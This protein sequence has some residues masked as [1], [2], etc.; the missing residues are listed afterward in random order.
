MAPNA[1]PGR[2]GARPGT[3]PPSPRRPRTTVTEVRVFGRPGPDD[4]DHGARDDRCP[5]SAPGRAWPST[6]A[7][8]SSG[9][10]RPGGALLDPCEVA[11]YDATLVGCLPDPTGTPRPAPPGRPPAPTAHDRPAPPYRLLVLDGGDR[12]LPI[13]ATEPTRPPPPAVD[14]DHPDDGRRD[15]HRAADLGH[16][17]P[18]DGTDDGDVHRADRGSSTTTATTAADRGRGDHGRGT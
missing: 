16:R 3:A 1:G 4:V 2:P 10:A 7:P 13:P 18:L 17:A 14:D 8:G 5:A 11:P 12:C 9:A 15:E 6:A